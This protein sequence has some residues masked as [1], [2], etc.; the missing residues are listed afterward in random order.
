LH[1]FVTRLSGHAV[2]FGASKSSVLF[3]PF[4]A[5]WLLSKAE[6]G[7][8]EWWLSLSMTLGP[9][10]ALGA[11]GVVAYG[12]LGGV[13]TPY[14]RAAVMY[15]CLV[16]SCALLFVLLLPVAGIDW[17]VSFVGVVTLQSAMVVLQLAL[18]ARLKGLGKGAWASLAESALYIALMLSLL[19]TVVGV[20][21]VLGFMLVMIAVEL[22]MLWLLIKISDLPSANYW[23]H[24]DY[25]KM[26]SLSHKFFIGGTL[27]GAF[28]A[29]PRLLMGG[30]SDATL[31]ASFSIVFRWLSIAIIIH[32]F[33]NTFYF[34]QIYR[35]DLTKRKFA[36]LGCVGLV[37]IFSVLIAFAVSSQFVRSFNIPLPDSNDIW[38]VWSMAGV[39]IL[40][41]ASA[42]FEGVLSSA[43]RVMSQSIAVALGLIVFLIIFGSFYFTGGTD[44]KFSL[45]IA[46]L[47]GFISMVAVQFIFIFRSKLLG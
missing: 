12:S 22:C 10:M 45:T 46:W 15:V 11:H 34:R 29:G 23:F 43:G 1:S 26:F 13:F 47:A 16:C 17:K 37:A 44:H 20:D 7:A 35:G 40:W 38:L 19:L 3:A 39:M 14:V 6:Y 32:Q 28:M 8:L 21:F 18:S 42:S 31:V 24:E 33:I 4:L 25:K 41:S 27:M 2:L 9:I 5:A 30:I 36:L